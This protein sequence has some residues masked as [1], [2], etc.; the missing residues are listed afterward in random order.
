MV[1]VVLHK[2]MGGEPL[3]LADVSPDITAA[4]LK[5]IVDKHWQI[6]LRCQKLLH[7]TDHLSDSDSLFLHCPLDDSPLSLV[8][9]VSLDEVYEDIEVGRMQQRISG[10]NV[11]GHLG[12]RGD[13]RSVKTVM[14]CAWE[15]AWEI[16][17]A[18]L[19]ALCL[20]ADEGDERAIETAM[21]CL[22]DRRLRQTSV[23]ALGAMVVRGDARVT[24]ALDAWLWD[25]H[26]NDPNTR[27]AALEALGVIAEKGD[28]HMIETMSG[29]L[30]DSDAQTRQAAVEALTAVAEQGDKRVV[31]ALLSRLDDHNSSVRQKAMQALITV[32]E[33]GDETT[34]NAVTAHLEGRNCEV[35]RQV[36]LQ[37]LR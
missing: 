16:R 4:D 35:M 28:D 18:A 3:E 7:G 6:P 15:G 36:L 9:L 2:G 14:A 21:R 22:R 17:H 8:V 26:E 10:L 20:V 12:K 25:A 27:Q 5:K 1:R 37:A 34:I 31:N 11:L 33:K 13:E 32:V 24:A 30:E 29:F 23:K 19:L